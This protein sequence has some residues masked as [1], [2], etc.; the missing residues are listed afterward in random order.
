MSDGLPPLIPPEPVDYEK[1][2]VTVYSNQNEGNLRFLLEDALG[3][4][5]FETMYIRKVRPGGS[6]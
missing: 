4:K 5:D 2:F 1:R 6:S 3:E